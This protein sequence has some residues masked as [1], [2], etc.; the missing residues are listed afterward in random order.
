MQPFSRTLATML[1]AASL[2]VG[3]CS[4]GNDAPS[5]NATIE[6]F[7]ATPQVYMRGEAV[8]LRWRVEDALLLDLQIYRG[9]AMPD[10]RQSWSCMR[11]GADMV[12]TAPQI[13][14]SADGWSC[15]A[16]DCRKPVDEDMEGYGSIPL[17]PDQESVGNYIA[18]VDDTTT[19][20]LQAEGNG[21]VV[22]TAWVQVV[23]ND[24]TGARIVSFHAWP[25]PALIGEEVTVAYRTEG[26]DSVDQVSATPM[27]TS[28]ELVQADGNDNVR[29][30]YAWL[31]ATETRDF[32]LGCHPEGEV[33]TARIRSHITV[34]VIVLPEVCERIDVFTVTPATEVAPGTEVEVRWQ[35]SNAD[36]V[37]GESSPETTPPFYIGSTRF[38][39]TWTGTVSETT[40]FNISAEGECRVAAA[41]HTVT[42]VDE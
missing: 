2:A 3:A 6:A 20:R 23:V 31:E 25:T 13:P 37:R 17:N 19:F 5:L 30:T 33:D 38:S 36:W 14:G 41:S 1:L 42:V 18:W 24:G 11:E 7:T 40:T 10:G 29:G 16:T 15:S 32:Y 12:C 9:S 39:G 22:A 4:D 8:E 21:G 27:L 26:C 35:V 34:P 28:S